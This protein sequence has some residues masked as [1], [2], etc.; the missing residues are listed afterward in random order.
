MSR[1]VAFL[2][3]RL[4]LRFSAVNR[5]PL[6]FYWR[7]ELECSADLFWTLETVVTCVIEAEMEKRLF[8]SFEA[9][10]DIVLNTL[11]TKT[12]ITCEL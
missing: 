9:Q 7:F 2:I 6:R 12:A 8:A 1:I 4:R 3:L 11:F 10:F 5:S